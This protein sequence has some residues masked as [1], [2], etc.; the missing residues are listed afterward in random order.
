MHLGVG[1]LPNAETRPRM[2]LSHCATSGASKG[3]AAGNPE[4]RVAVV[5]AAI[6][7]E[8]STLPVVDSEDAKPLSTSYWKLTDRS[9]ELLVHQLFESRGHLADKLKPERVQLLNEGADRGRDIVLLAAQTPIGVVQCKLHKDRLSRP[10][11]IREIARFVM[12]AMLDEQLMKPGTDLVYV[13][14]AP[15]GLSEEAQNVFEQ[16]THLLHNEEDLIRRCAGEVHE[17]YKGLHAL[18]KAKAID[19]VV[20][21]LRTASLYCLKSEDLDAWLAQRENVRATFFSVRMVVDTAPVLEAIAGLGQQV[22]QAALSGGELEADSWS[23]SA[24]ARSYDVVAR[25]PAST[26]GAPILLEDVYVGRKLQSEVDRWLSKATPGAPG[27]LIFVVAPGGFGKTS[28]LWHCHRTH[29]ERAGEHALLF[30]ASMIEG[31]LARGE[32]DSSLAALVQRVKRHGA[33]GERVLVCLD[34][35]DVLVHR[36]DLRD[37]G[38]VVV[39]RLLSAGASVLVSSRPEEAASVPI[40]AMAHLNVRLLLDEYEE[41]EFDAAVARYCE[42]FYA[43]TP[44]GVEETRAQ[45]QRLREL[46]ALGRPVRSV[47][48]NPLTL[49]MLFEL[50]APA[51]IPDDVNSFQL[52]SEYWLKRVLK[53]QRAGIAAGAGRDLSAAVRWA[54]STMFQQGAPSLS[55]K[56]ITQAIARRELAESDKVELL[57]RNLMRESATTALE[58]FHQT[59]FEHAAARYLDASGEMTLDRCVADMRAVANDPFRLPVYEQLF[60]L[61]AARDGSSAALG[62]HVGDLLA[63]VH[64]ALSGVGLHAYVLDEQGY[65]P[66]RR[67]L[68]DAVAAGDFHLLKRL[69]QRIQHLPRTRA[70]E[71]VELLRLGWPARNWNRMELFASLLAWL[72]QADW[73]VGR[74]ELERTD[75]VA[76]LGDFTAQEFTLDSERLAILVLRHGLPADPLWVVS[77]ALRFRRQRHHPRTILEFVAAEAGRLPIKAAREAA[78]LV[79]ARF[80]D[81]AAQ[82]ARRDDLAI[83]PAA[84]CLAALWSAHETLAP[85]DAQAVGVD[86]SARS[87]LMLRAVAICSNAGLMALKRAI[88]ERVRSERRP[89]VLQVLMR[90]FVSPLVSSAAL[91]EPYE[92]ELNAA[93]LAV[94]SS[95]VAGHSKIVSWELVSLYAE[96]AP[97]SLLWASL[98]ARPAESWLDPS[99]NPRLMA[100]AFAT[101]SPEA[102]DALRQMRAKPQVHEGQL[103]RL[104]RALSVIPANEFALRHVLSVA[105]VADVPQL[106]AGLRQAQAADAQAFLASA[107]SE[108]RTAIG[109]LARRAHQSRQAALRA[110]GLRLLAFLARRGAAPLLSHGEV[111]AWLEQESSANVRAAGRALL[112]AVTQASTCSETVRAILADV[113]GADVASLNDP[114]HALHEVLALPGVV[115]PEDVRASVQAF[116]LSPVAGEP[117]ISLA[118][119]LIS[120]CLAANDVRSANAVSLAVIRGVRGRALSIAQ[121]NALGHHLDK[122]FVAL[123]RRN[124]G[125][126]MAEHLRELR[127]LDEHLGRLVAVSLCKSGRVD[128]PVL[129]D[130]V[131]ADSQVSVALKPIV[132]NFRQHVLGR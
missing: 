87:R 121:K 116:A 129:L 106:L 126:A 71:I 122:P 75:F 88:V 81:K 127:L 104:K 21:T 11:V 51:E 27:A 8:L 110:A 3:M 72:A 23:R 55:R 19:H 47:C 94:A 96:K 49:R 42:A 12:A 15:G 56:L 18:D 80:S 16:T 36:E 17:K 93:L 132:Q 32:L 98:A 39:G 83:A 31:K 109:D 77:Q 118:G 128:L 7:A 86:S 46:V 99:A 70:S 66:G 41:D 24:E 4:L 73:E 28:L 113:D 95:T 52:Y 33:A 29:A 92:A 85:N 59:F 61:R 131:I 69:A 26:G 79:T 107:I 30:G 105:E 117:Q 108:H 40:E 64:P 37:A 53:D 62:L 20:A 45:I 50:Y 68:E 48:L 112:V 13:L 82:P 103:E 67:V 57:N 76:V 60:L 78:S 5:P 44:A 63:D 91:L 124:T 9:F 25:A 120:L 54:A 34:T 100:I 123:Y 58:F 90:Q 125:E 89:A 1:W 74:R 102:A 65:P 111:L 97:A 2:H 101:G 84:H 22:Q 38:M 35:F 6:Q 14:A 10:E 119:R 130:G 114:V 115:L 43:A